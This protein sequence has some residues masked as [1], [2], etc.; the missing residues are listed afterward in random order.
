VTDLPTGNAAE[1][2]WD[3]L[4]RRKVVQWGLV[5]AAGAWGL[6]QGLEYVTG[7]FDWPRQI[8]QLS[9]LALLIGLP[10]VLVTAWYHGDQGRQRVSAAELTI[11]TLLFL[12]GGGI[13]WRYDKAG[14]VPSPAVPSIEPAGAGAASAAAGIPDRSIAVLPFVNMSGDPDNEY[15][16]DG[17]SEEILNVLAGTPELQVAARTSSFSFKG[18]SMEVPEIAA[19]LNVR[20]V[21]EGSVRRQGNKVRITAQLIDAQNGFHLWSQ[22]Y[23]RNLEDIFAIQDEIARAIGDELKVK[24]VSPTSPGQDSSGTRNLEAYELYLRGMALWH[25]RNEEKLWQA[26]DLFKQ[27]IAADPAYAQAYGGL[28]LAYGVLPDYSARISYEDAFRRVNDAAGMALGLDPTLPEPYAALSAP[29][30][31]ERR[32]QTAI[33]LYRRAIAIRP[34]FATA[35]QWLGTDTMA[36]GDPQAGLEAL[37]RASELDPRSL[38]VAHNRS[39]V[40]LTLGRVADARTNCERVLAFAPEYQGCQRM[41]ALAELVRGDF[42]AARPFLEAVARDGDGSALP[43]VD[44]VINA[45]KGQGDREAVAQRLAAFPGRS[46]LDPTSGNIFTTADAPVLLVLLGAPEL[47]LGYLERSTDE[48]ESSTNLPEWPMMLPALDPI[49]CTPRFK[50]LVDRLK[51]RDPRAA[52]VCAG[53][54]K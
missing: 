33:T 52:T 50:A 32:R 20:M 19:I 46:A 41:V 8:Q 30:S 10:V 51:T 49:R 35:Y 1:S 21:L 36:G 7:T 27:A 12:V 6:L 14:D 3:K 44:A 37:D 39:Y 48:P 5:Y 26:V 16:S 25:T 28:G 43:L 54:G 23:D 24:I 29:A 22:T 47:A 45:L 13:F 34:S 11:I 31:W 53:G 40:L 4:R 15:F 42:D 38:V 17:I 2:A 18:K 9:T